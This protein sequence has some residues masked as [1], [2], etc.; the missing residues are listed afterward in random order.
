M[1]Q[2]QFFHTKISGVHTVVPKD[3]IRLEDELQYFK[4]DIK[5]AQRMTK[6]VGMDC[7]RVA[8]PGVTPSDLSRQAAEILFKNMKLDPASV[9]AIIFLSQRPDHLVPATA[10]ILQKKLGLS[11]NCAAFDVNQGCSG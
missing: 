9:D 6:M 5:K 7:R 8:Q 10:C 11:K 2:S 3:A 4:G 1:A